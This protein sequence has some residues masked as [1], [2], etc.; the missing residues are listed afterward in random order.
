MQS[1]KERLISFSK[2][3]ASDK[4]S[5]IHLALSGFYYLNRGDEV[6]CAY[7]K[8]EIMNWKQGDNPLVDHKRWA[9]QCKFAK[10]VS[11]LHL[12]SIMNDD[13][14]DNDEEEQQQQHDNTTSK[15]VCGSKAGGSSS[16][17]GPRHSF[18]S[19]YENRL[20]SYKKW[21]IEIAQRPIDLA[22]A[23][24][25]YT[26]RGVEV[27][28]FQSDCGLSDWEP[29]DD[30]WREH[31]RWFPKCEYVIAI[32][33]KDYIQDSVSKACVVRE[34]ASKA[35]ATEDDDIVC[36]ICFDRRRNTCFVPCGHVIACAECAFIVKNC[37]M[38]RHRFT[39]TQRLFFV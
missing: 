29:T 28:C 9:P 34:T 21:P 33:G 12:A 27:R 25:F 26:G 36:K 35:T 1:F 19:S 15:D 17:D 14:N 7:C 30:P 22:D 6:R 37:P 24:F 16:N 31:A 23:G 38:C 20:E 39:H 32:K 13:D 4:V 3:P 2:W 10:E 11:S 5:P 18:Y 8:V